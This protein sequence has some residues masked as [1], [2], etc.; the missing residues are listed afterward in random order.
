MTELCDLANK[1]GTDKFLYYTPYYHELFKDR[2]NEIKTLLEVGIGYP[3]TML[4]SVIRMGRTSY[5]IGASLFMWREYF[6]AANIFAIDNRNDIMVDEFRIK[7]Y[8][9]D[10]EKP[11]TME[12][13][14]LQMR[15]NFDFIIDDGMH[16]HASQLSTAKHLL[17]TLKLDGIYVIEDVGDWWAELVQ[18]L[19]GLFYKAELVEFGEARIIVVKP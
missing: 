8:Y 5:K 9:A 4:S 3:G 17:P 10:Q 19:K 11:E 12:A 2:R 14:I 13:V 16:T 6:P 15:T 7:S 1:W 18:E